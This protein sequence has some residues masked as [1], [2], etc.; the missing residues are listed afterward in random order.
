LGA[1]PAQSA[2][3]QAALPPPAPGAEA[4]L[5]SLPIHPE[6][7]VSVIVPIYGKLDYTLRCLRSIAM[8]R[9]AVP[10]EVI[11]VDD[12]SPDDSAEV[13]AGVQGIRLERNAKNLGFIRSCNRGA[14]LAKG[15]HVLFLNNDTEVHPNWLDEL[16]RTFGIFPGTGLVGSKL[17]YPDGTLQEAGGIIWRDGTVR[18]HGR[19]DSP[20]KSSFEHVR[21]A[22]K[23]GTVFLQ[24]PASMLTVQPPFQMSLVMVSTTKQSTLSCCWIS[25]NT[26][27][28]TTV[29]RWP[30]MRKDGS[31]VT[32][33]D[34]GCARKANVPMA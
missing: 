4:T 8:H 5:P 10:F 18:N 2:P 31:A 33:I 22:E 28:L 9:P 1:P 23:D 20:Y 3:Q 19:G 11:V 25:L 17:I 12:C 26:R 30:G 15:T 14:A 32:L 6:P 21:D 7:V 24:T 27:M 34:C 29:V 13:L 16:Y